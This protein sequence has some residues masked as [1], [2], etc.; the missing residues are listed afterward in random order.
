MSTISWKA[1]R[2]Y[3]GLLFIILLIGC[4]DDP[5]NS[6]DQA[7]D[8]AAGRTE[9]ANEESEEGESTERATSSKQEIDTEGSTSANTKNP[10]QAKI[11]SMTMKE[12]IGQMLMF[13]FEGTK[14]NETTRRLIE[15]NHIGGVILFE[16]N[17]TDSQQLTALNRELKEIKVGSQEIPLFISVDEE[18]GSV[19]RMPTEIIKLPDSE[20]I[21]DRNSKEL[22]FKVGEAIGE[23]VSTFG[24]NISMA[25]V[26][27]INSNPQNPVIGKRAFGDNKEVVSKMG[28]AEMKGIQSKG[29]VPVIKHFPGHGDTSVDSHLGLPV[30]NHNLQSLRKRELVPF[31]KAINY[32]ADMTMVAH[33]LLPAIDKE[34][35]SSLS[36]NVITTLLREELGFKGLVITDDMTMGAILENYDIGDATV[37]AVQAGN[38][39]VLVCHGDK[40]KRKALNSLTKAVKDGTI[41]EARVNQSV[42]RILQLKEKY[43]LSDAPIPEINVDKINQ[44]SKEILRALQET[45]QGVADDN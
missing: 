45:E 37:K 28:I 31:K 25:P 16:K 15:N 4:S 32:Q 6:L 26:M 23:R 14:I 8:E 20:E 27:D 36:E 35:P 42:E 40:N 5:E 10:V 7:N 24:F 41:T 22:A 30:V 12:K 43:N 44:S 3:V 11:A 13:G 2:L 18:G 29:V 1:I 17:V 34:Y 33:I 19:S 21:G 39:I 9:Q 38:D